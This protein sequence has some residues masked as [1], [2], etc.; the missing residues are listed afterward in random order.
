MRVVIGALLAAAT[1]AGPATADE[2]LRLQVR[3]MPE[4]DVALDL[5][6]L[7]AIAG[8][9]RRIWAPVLDVVVTLPAARHAPSLATPS[10]S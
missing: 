2:R 6:D 4:R 10:Q 3:L 8:D 9:V 7:Q 1:V 5:S